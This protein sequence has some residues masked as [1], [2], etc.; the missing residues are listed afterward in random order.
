[1]FARVSARAA[2]P[3]AAL[4]ALTALA[5]RQTAPPGMNV[6]AA[7]AMQLDCELQPRILVVASPMLQMNPQVGSVGGSRICVVSIPRLPSFWSARR[8]H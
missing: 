3:L 7:A 1:M 4:A 6:V 5:L 8:R 2:L